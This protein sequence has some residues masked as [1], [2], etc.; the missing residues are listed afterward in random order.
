ML[1]FATKLNSPFGLLAVVVDGQQRLVAL[2]FVEAGK[3][4]AARRAVERIAPDAVWN[5]AQCEPAVT[6]LKEYFAHKRRQFSLALALD[7]T[8]FQLQ[9]WHALLDIPY[10]QTT[11]YGALARQL[12]MPL[13]ASRA[14]GRANATNPVAIVVPCHR[15]IGGGGGLTGYAGGLPVKEALLAHEGALTGSLWGQ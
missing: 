14:V 6:Q 9:V 13:S 7:G 11:S 4:G 3:P 8:P 5:A 15:V 10:G 2:H 12:G 1:H